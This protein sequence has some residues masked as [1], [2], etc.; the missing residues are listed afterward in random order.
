MF[1]LRCNFS[2]ERISELGINSNYRQFNE[3][4]TTISYFDG[5]PHIQAQSSQKGLFLKLI[6]GSLQFR[7]R[8]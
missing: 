6:F 7:S 3:E 8:T 1:S 5:L 4:R 2:L